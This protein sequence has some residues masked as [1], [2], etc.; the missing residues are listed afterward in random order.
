MD[1]S[2]PDPAYLFIT[3]IIR[4]LTQHLAQQPA[5]PGLDVAD[6]RTGLADGG[7]GYFGQ[8]EA[9][10]PGRAIRAAEGAIAD[11]KRNIRQVVTQ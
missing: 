6:L 10:G 9:S 3:A 1:D 5:L 11:L 2:R 7:R 4:S 8:A